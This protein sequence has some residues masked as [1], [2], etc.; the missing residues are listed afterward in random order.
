M[1]PAPVRTTAC[2]GAARTPN[3]PS[4]LPARR[5]QTN[6]PSKLIALLA[7][8]EDPGVRLQLLG[9]PALSGVA[10][11]RLLQ[12]VARLGRHAGGVVDGAVADGLRDGC[13]CVSDQV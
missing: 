6:K 8:L 12:E 3:K 9:G 5:E 2:A 10:L 4:N 1:P 11:E 7:P 13:R